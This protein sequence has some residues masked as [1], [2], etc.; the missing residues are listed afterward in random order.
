MP[1]KNG[2]ELCQQIR[3]QFGREL[4]V[5]LCSTLFG[6]TADEQLELASCFDAIIAKP[7]DMQ[8]LQNEVS[9]L[10]SKKCQV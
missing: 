7:I 10:L 1:I 3:H 4:P 5:I 2:L 9:T 6:K 8:L